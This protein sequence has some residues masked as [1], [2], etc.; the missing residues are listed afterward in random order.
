MRRGLGSVAAAGLIVLVAAAPTAGAS[1]GAGASH[2][3]TTTTTTVANS[4]HTGTS[5]PTGSSQP[6]SGSGGSSGGGSGNG[7]NSGSGGQP[8]GTTSTSSSTTTTTTQPGTAPTENPASDSAVP[9]FG[10]GTSFAA[11]QAWMLTALGDRQARLGEL[12]STIAS[13][14]SLSSN[15]RSSLA[16][17]VGAAN[18]TCSQLRSSVPTDT[19]SAQLRAAASEMIGSLHVY[20]ILTPQVNLTIAADA[21]AA[22]AAKLQALEPGLN[23]AIAASHATKAELSRLRALEQAFASAAGDAAGI[24]GPLGGQLAGLS[25]AD[26]A[27]ALPVLTSAQTAN[28]DAQ[29]NLSA[30]D[31]DLRKLLSL[32]ASAGRKSSVKAKLSGLDRAARVALEVDR[33]S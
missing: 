7:P 14:K 25:D 18:T 10:A 2:R 15:D 28:E 30:A 26:L 33:R 1:I 20:A 3:T 29:N 6:S 8:S 9:A 4:A 19:T 5:R 32:L 24:A 12:S 23:T 31:T 17:L 27:T 11:D 16:G 21:N 13:S 22:S